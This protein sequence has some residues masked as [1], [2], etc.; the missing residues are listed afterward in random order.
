MNQEKIGKF[1]AENRKNKNLTQEKLSEKLGVSINA[2]SKWERGLNLPDTGLMQELCKILGITLNE[3]FSGEKI[4]D[5][6]YKEVTD[7]NLL[8]ALE[9]SVFTLEDKID[10]FKKKWQKEHFFELTVTMVIIVF[11][12]IYGFVKDNGL[13]YLFMIIG[14]I[15][16]SIENNKMMT[17]IKENAYGKNYN[18]I[19]GEFRNSISRLKETKKIINEFS[20]KKQAIDFLVNETNLSKQ[21]CSVAYDFIKN[22]DLDKINKLN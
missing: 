2:V 1:I 8:K 13:Q 7:K 9:N 6:K 19:I 21:E 16:G 17:Y 15:C 11:F 10:Y 20:N 3:L 14:I 5:C 18:I 12:I 4:P 22:I